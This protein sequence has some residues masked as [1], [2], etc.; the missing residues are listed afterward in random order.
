MKSLFALIMLVLISSQAW[1]IDVIDSTS[2][3]GSGTAITVTQPTGGQ[4]GDL[5]VIFINHNR[6]DI[7]VTDNNGGVATRKETEI[8]GAAGSGSLSVFWR[9]YVSG[10][11]PAT[12]AFTLGAN[13]RWVAI[14][15]IFRGVQKPYPFNVAPVDGANE[16]SSAPTCPTA[17]TTV[18]KTIAFAFAGLD[19]TGATIDSGPSGFT[20]LETVN[21]QQATS[22]YYKEIT[23]A[24]AIG[25][26]DF[27]L[28]GST[29]NYTMTMFAIGPQYPGIYQSTLYASTLY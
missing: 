10:L 12:Y 8:D 28:S 23:P 11:D 9:Y 4:N 24:G 1:A 25:N 17:T 2:N 20:V 3:S 22:V 27:T 7:N 18:D 16:T 5:V 6:E 13:D 14:A 19:G 15:G 29:S 21:A 26:Q